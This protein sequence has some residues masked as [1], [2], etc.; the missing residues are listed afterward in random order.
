MWKILTLFLKPENQGTWWS[1]IGVSLASADHLQSLLKSIHLLPISHQT[2]YIPTPQSVFILLLKVSFPFSFFWLSD[3]LP[4][5][6]STFIL[7]PS[8]DCFC[9]STPGLSFHSLAIFLNSLQCIYIE[10][11]DQKSWQNL[12]PLCIYIYYIHKNYFTVP[13][14]NQPHLTQ[15]TNCLISLSGSYYSDCWSLALLSPHLSNTQ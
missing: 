15:L 13:H 5:N 12:L 2:Q 9:P 11:Q 10:I 6:D 14:E 8:Q 1:L 4:G 3:H 7:C